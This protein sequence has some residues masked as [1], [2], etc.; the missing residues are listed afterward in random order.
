MHVFLAFRARL[1]KVDVDEQLQLAKYTIQL[2]LI[3]YLL[4]R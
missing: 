3:A 1:R 4:Q 2:Y